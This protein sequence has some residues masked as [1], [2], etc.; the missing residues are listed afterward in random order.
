M[1]IYT[2]IKTRSRYDGSTTTSEFTGTLE[3]LTNDFSYTLECGHSWNQRINRH[4]KTI[5]GLLSAINSS[6][7]VKGDYNSYVELKAA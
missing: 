3:E 1:K 2:I 6:Y 5:R 7:Q 4:P